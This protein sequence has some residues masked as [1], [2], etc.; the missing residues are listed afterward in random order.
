M[1]I[2][3]RL[4]IKLLRRYLSL[5]LSGKVRLFLHPTSRLLLEGKTSYLGL[6][7]WGLISAPDTYSTLD[8]R[9]NAQLILHAVSIGR[10]ARIAVGENAI[11]KIGSHTYLSDDCFISSSTQVVIGANCAISWQVQI[12]DDDGHGALGKNTQ[13]PIKI[14]ERV[15]IGA[16]AIILK[17]SEIGDNCIVAAGA[18]VKGKFPSGCLIGGVPARVLR[19]NV[20]WKS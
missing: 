7:I 13:A 16:R 9:Q 17:G 12:F 14:G 18:V 20:K 6:P 8:L 10:G 4:T 5:R 1:K 19:E 3:D 15:W 2:R 11:L